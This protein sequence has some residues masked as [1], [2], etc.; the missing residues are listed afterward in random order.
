[1]SYV[2]ARP[3]AGGASSGDSR[4]LYTRRLRVQF[5]LAPLRDRML[6]NPRRSEQLFSGPCS[7]SLAG[8]LCGLVDG[9]G[10]ITGKPHREDGAAFLAFGNFGASALVFHGSGRYHGFYLQTILFVLHLFVVRE[11]TMICQTS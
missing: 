1:M 8:V 5:P 4:G 6:L 9:L 7:R 2:A 11:R 3:V 10:F